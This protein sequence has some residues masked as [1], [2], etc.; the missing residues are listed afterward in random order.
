MQPFA[1]CATVPVC[2]AI[3]YDV[4]QENRDLL[5]AFM[6]MIMMET[7]KKKNKIIL[8]YSFMLHLLEVIL[9]QNLIPRK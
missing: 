8:L 2:G 1:S 3:S 9:K 7:L 6:E 4:Y 5:K